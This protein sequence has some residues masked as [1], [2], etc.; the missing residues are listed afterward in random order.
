MLCYNALWKI[1]HFDQNFQSALNLG[2]SQ[3]TLKTFFFF[4]NVL[5]SAIL[6]HYENI[7]NIKF[8]MAPFIFLFSKTIINFENESISSNVKCFIEDS[9]NC[10]FIC[11]GC[12]VIL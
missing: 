5:I 4:Q 11:Q 6:T 3:L 1:T 8:C 7:S 9:I 10:T 2:P 12:E